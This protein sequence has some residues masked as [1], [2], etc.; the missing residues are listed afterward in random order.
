MGKSEGVVMLCVG[1]LV[2]LSLQFCSFIFRIRKA[3]IVYRP[4]IDLRLPEIGAIVKAIWPVLLG[5]LIGQASPLI[6]Q[7]FASFLSTGSISSLSY[8]LKIVSVCSSVIFA[9]VGRAAL[10]Y[11]SRQVANKDMKSF[12]GTLR[13]YLWTVGI[14]TTV[15]SILV[16]LLAHPIVQLLFQR[17]AFSA[18]DTDRTAV[19]LVGFIFGLAPMALGTI[20]SRAF[21]A[22]GKNHVLMGVS[23]FSIIADVILMLSA[24]TFGRLRVLRLLPLS[25]IQELC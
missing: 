18:E 14:V 25:T 13:L 6:D 1:T 17:G 2:G 24:V 15:L 20:T 12:K 4:I 10:P 16:I 23:I 22:L 21:S 19:V 11:L 9:S 5:S 7:I 3:K 8:A